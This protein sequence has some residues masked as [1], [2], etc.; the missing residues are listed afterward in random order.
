MPSHIQLGYE[1]PS[2]TLQ[3]LTVTAAFSLPSRL[4]PNS[5]RYSPCLTVCISI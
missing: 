2:C 5:N 1:V 3:C 4:Y